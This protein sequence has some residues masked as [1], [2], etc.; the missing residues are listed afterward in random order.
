MNKDTRWAVAAACGSVGTRSFCH[1]CGGTL[2]LGSI[3]ATKPEPQLQLL[4]PCP[5][6]RTAQHWAAGQ[7]GSRSA[8]LRVSID[9]L[10]LCLPLQQEGAAAA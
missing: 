6:C 8:G 5:S 9:G 2:D 10:W 3:P 7:A 1:C 4:A